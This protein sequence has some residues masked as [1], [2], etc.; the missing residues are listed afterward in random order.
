MRG[1]L[2]VQEQAAYEQW[3]SEQTAQAAA[4]AAGAG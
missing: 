3:S 4:A 1:F 2:H